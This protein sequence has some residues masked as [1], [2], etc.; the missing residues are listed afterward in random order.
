MIRH[1]RHGSP[2]R[3]M[4]LQSILRPNRRES[5]P[6]PS[7]GVRMTG[8]GP[9]PEGPYAI[10]F[11]KAA[12]RRRGKDITIVATQAM[13]PRAITAA[14]DLARDGIDA[15]VIA[16]RTLWPL[17]EDAI[18]TSVRKTHRLV[19]AQEA[20]V[21][22]G[23]GAEL[24]AVVQERAFDWL[25]APIVRVGAPRVPMPYNDALERYVIPSAQR[26]AEASR[27]SCDGMGA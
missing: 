24:A 26:I 25:D 3:L 4:V 23:F 20:P 13:V 9:V 2:P 21:Q 12:V 8:K 19:I 15:E 11:G 14:N 6:T 7:A 17:D 5:L 18:L 16:P 1:M 10:P 22:H 27:C